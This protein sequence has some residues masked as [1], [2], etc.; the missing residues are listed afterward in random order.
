MQQGNIPLVLTGT[1]VGLISL[2]GYTPD[3]FASATF[4]YLLDS[5]PGEVG[6]QNV[7]WMLTG[8]SIVGGIASFVY[9][10]L[11]GKKV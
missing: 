11:H 9:Y 3:I 7:F 8:F 6:H 4:G 2:V 5:N 10:R 1:A